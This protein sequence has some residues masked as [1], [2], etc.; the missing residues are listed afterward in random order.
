MAASETPNMT[1]YI[2]NKNLV[3]PTTCSPC[4]EHDKCDFD[5]ECMKMISAEAVAEAACEQIEIHRRPLETQT[6]SI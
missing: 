6:L 1:G 4:W 5:R 3:G 2:A